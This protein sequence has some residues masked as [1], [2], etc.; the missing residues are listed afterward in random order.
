MDT[1]MIKHIREKFLAEASEHGQAVAVGDRKKANKIHKRLQQLYSQAKE[2]NQVNIF[3]EFMNEKH[4]NVRLW[5][6]IFSLTVYPTIAEKS[7]QELTKLTTITGLTA[8][9]TLQL[10]KEGRLNLL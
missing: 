5:A 7:L 10:W 8:K 3:A 4:E 1:L 6:A 2:H 9:T